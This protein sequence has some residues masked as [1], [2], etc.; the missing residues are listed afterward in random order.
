[1]T[2]NEY[3]AADLNDDDSVFQVAVRL[4]DQAVEQ[5]IPE[6]ERYTITSA[7]REQM[8]EAAAEIVG[9]MAS[10]LDSM[11]VCVLAYIGRAAN[12]PD[13]ER[14]FASGSKDT[15][16]ESV[17]PLATAV[18]VTAGVTSALSMNLVSNLVA[19]VCLGKAFQDT[20]DPTLAVFVPEGRVAMQRLDTFYEITRQMIAIKL[21]RQDRS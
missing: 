10:E 19:H 12:I 21:G 20:R 9:T 5:A 11:M 4:I 1:M 3:H 18:T 6:A 7:Q 13:L 2:N 14:Q 17:D 15:A 8:A 16:R